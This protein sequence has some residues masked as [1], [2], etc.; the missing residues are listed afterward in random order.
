M[1][2]K[3]N[4]EIVTGT[5][6]QPRVRYPGTVIAEKSASM[7]EWARGSYLW[8]A[9]GIVLLIFSN[10]IHY[11]M[12]IATWLAPLFLI[13]FLRTQPKAKGLIIFALL[14]CI[15]WGIMLFGIL[16]DLGV[17]G[18]GFGVFYGIIFFLPYLADRLIA[19]K[20]K[21]FRATFIFPSVW[22][23]LEFALASFEFTGSWFAWAFTQ[24]DN[25]PLIQLASIT[26]SYGISFLINWF[27]SVANWAWEQEF[28]LPKVWQGVSLYLGIL[29]IAL[30][31]GSAYLT[32]LPANSETV[33]TAAVTR[34]F[35]IDEEAAKCKADVPC[36]TAL[37]GRTLDEFLQGSQ[38][39]VNAGAK[40]IVWQ[41]NGLT[42]YQEDEAAYIEQG[43]D[44]AMQEN[45]YLVMGTKMVAP[46]KVDD[47][48]KIVF[49][50]PEGEIS[51]YL[52]NHKVAGDEHRLGDGKVLL[53]DSPYGKFA[54]LICYDADFPSFVRQAGQAKAD[55]MLIPAQ[56]W[57]EITPLHGRMPALGAIENGYSLIRNGYHGVSIAVDY[58]GE[59]LSQ[60]NN[61]TTD[62]RVMIADLPT[63]GITT[64]YSRI[65]DVF[66]WLCVFGSLGFIV[67]AVKNR[68]EN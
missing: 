15:A 53:Q 45:V 50:N 7:L 19:P 56:D 47:E 35:D 24:L 20:T 67:L 62:E 8:L 6:T 32:F 5:D 39:A 9:I 55:I 17:I 25:L 4:V 10:G 26:G 31:F 23:I 43:R 63:Q 46:E 42:V 34:S 21:G 18:N 16:P 57:A 58:H 64:V 13:R 11:T 61:F 41:E 59:M 12:P 29:L 33:R 65:G 49:I 44:F 38:K 66:A 51:A 54:A 37:F 14:N 3:M 48:N 40:I 30:L 1:S 60:L 2:E 28:S 52:K 22:V 36:L 27:A 68:K